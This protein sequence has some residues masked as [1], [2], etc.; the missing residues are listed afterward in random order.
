VRPLATTTR[1]TWSRSFHPQVVLLDITPPT[2]SAASLVVRMR[3][4]YA[5]TRVLILVDEEP[6]ELAPELV[7]AGASAYVT[8]HV[9]LL[10]MAVAIKAVAEW[11]TNDADVA[12]PYLGT[13]PV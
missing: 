13:P 10:D 9:S 5:E 2:E 8:W 11:P 12:T 1:S 7:Q 4:A 3:G 6:G